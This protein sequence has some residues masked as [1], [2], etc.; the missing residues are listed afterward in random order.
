M[1]QNNLTRRIVFV[2][3]ICFTLIFSGL[4]A[5]ETN[6]ESWTP[7]LSMKYK[8]I[9]GT[10][11]SHDGSRIAYVV[12]EP[13]MEGEKSEYLSQIWVVSSDGKMNYQYT[14]GEK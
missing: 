10:A 14:H 6:E 8:S 3:L 9:R 4:K 1:K 12:R 5:Q 13:V 7:E 2:C 11:I